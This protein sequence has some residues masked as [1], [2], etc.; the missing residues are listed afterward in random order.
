MA[1]LI[2]NPHAKVNQVLGVP[3]ATYAAAKTALQT[4]FDAN[5]GSAF[6]DEATARATH[7]AFADDR[8]WATVKSE[9]GV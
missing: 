3:D 8:V 7:A 4:F 6:V 9:L 5:A 1:T 2:R